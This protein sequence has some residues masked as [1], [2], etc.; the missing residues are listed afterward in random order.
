MQV[1]RRSSRWSRWSRMRRCEQELCLG[2]G[3]EEPP[4]GGGQ[5]GGQDQGVEDGA[6]GQVRHKYEYSQKL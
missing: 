3:E 2:G 6:R 4:S 1:S 5:A